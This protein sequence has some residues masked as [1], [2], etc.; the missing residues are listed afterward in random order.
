MKSFFRERCAE[1]VRDFV[2]S[3]RERDE[4][5]LVSNTRRRER[6]RGFE[7]R[8][9]SLE[10]GQAEFDA[11]VAAASLEIEQLHAQLNE[12][13]MMMKFN[14]DSVS[15]ESGDPDI[16]ARV[17]NTTKARKDEWVEI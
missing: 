2:H 9:A 3:K 5:E 17:E 8:L 1:L 10:R 16:C 11:F 15:A 6:K 12:L 14:A 7:R 13:R 4:R